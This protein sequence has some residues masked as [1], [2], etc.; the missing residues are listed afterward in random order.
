MLH[1]PKAP[2]VTVQEAA[3]SVT[4]MQAEGTESLES[5]KKTQWGKANHFV[6][7]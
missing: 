4:R 7:H 1:L 6:G 2:H 5:Q 3:V